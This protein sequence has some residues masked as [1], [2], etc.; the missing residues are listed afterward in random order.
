MNLFTYGSLMIPSVFLMIT[1]KDL[2]PEKAYLQDY[3]RYCLKN[4]TY[5]AIIHS[6]G[7][8][9]EGILYREIDDIS[10]ERL[11]AFEGK[12]Y[13]R[14]PV[15]VFKTDGTSLSAMTYV[16]RHFFYDRLT[17]HSWSLTEFKEKHLEDFL[18]NF[19]GFTRKDDI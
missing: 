11:D 14:V 3:A 9:T 18:E 8:S 16:L 19:E 13:S 12:L 6:T 5:P 4:V 17:D 7:Q 15:F 2:M 1:G 10:I